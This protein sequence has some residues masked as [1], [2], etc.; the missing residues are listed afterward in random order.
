MEYDFCLIASWSRQS[1]KQLIAWGTELE[2]RDYTV[3]VVSPSS[4]KLLSECDLATFVLK[5]FEDTINTFPSVETI[6]S[7]YEITSLD[8]IVFTEQHYYT[9]TRSEALSR[10]V[11]VA[12]SIEKI[13][14]E[15]RFEYTLQT[16]GPEI[17]RLLSHYIT[18][19]ND[20]N[21]IWIEF[22]P[23][24]N[25]FAL[26]TSLDGRWAQYQTT[27]YEEISEKERESTRRH[28]EAF[29]EERHFYTQDEDAGD[30]SQN[31]KTFIQGAIG[32]I[33]DIVGRN[34][35][36]RLQDQI[37]QEA[38]L[39][40]NRLVN[41]YLLPT[42]EESRE[43]CRESK[44]VF[45]PLQYPIESRLTVFSPQFFDQLYLV[46]YLARI[47]PHSVD[48]FIKAHP[49]H[50]GR[51][52]PKSIRQLG[53]DN[54]ITFLHNN[55]HAHDVIQNAEAIVVVNNT[56]GYESI[57]LQKPLVALGNPTYAETPAVTKVED[58]KNLQQVVQNRI[59][60]T[61]SEDA[62]IESIYSLQETVWRGDTASY[63]IEN[64]QTMIDSI[65]KF[66]HE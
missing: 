14:S 6:E 45:F 8:H 47:L 66:L 34:Q 19:S 1:Q 12:A 53:E 42:V 25:S 4:S 23:F 35:P 27:P 50:P 20:K 49:N 44:Y 55:T 65:L 10:A 41:D 39:K 63:E 9:L 64:T 46:K 32:T 22:S 30:G 11:R 31:F 38:V 37:K 61:V 57:Y 40:F 56:I 17:H 26:T 36:G 33:Q 52:S 62:A 13:F 51:P 2:A 24:E 43:R 59:S 21:S 29:R 54:R 28:I 60:T 16:R 7:R 3:A 58:L 15:H 5:E 48:L 18:E